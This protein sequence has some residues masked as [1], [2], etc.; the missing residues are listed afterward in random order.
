VLEVAKEFLQIFLVDEDRLWRCDVAYLIRMM[1]AISPPL[2]YTS[3]LDFL[4]K[5]IRHWTLRA[6]IF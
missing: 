6:F 1:Y 4:K 5:E 2:I 3:N